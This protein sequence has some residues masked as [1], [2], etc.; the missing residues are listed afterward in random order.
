MKVGQRIKKIEKV[1]NASIGNGQDE[2]INFYRVSTEER[3]K[4]LNCIRAAQMYCDRNRIN[5]EK[6]PEE[7]FIAIIKDFGDK[8]EREGWSTGNSIDT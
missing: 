2:P 8:F 5:I 1:I 4:I 3:E 6:L 7:E